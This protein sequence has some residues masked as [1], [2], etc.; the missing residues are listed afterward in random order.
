VRPSAQYTQIQRYV[1]ANERGE[2]LLDSRGTAA[3]YAL[4]AQQNLLHKIQAHEEFITKTYAHLLRGDKYLIHDAKMEP[5]L[6]EY[7]LH[8]RL[9]WPD[10]HSTG[11]GHRSW[12]A[13]HPVL[14]NAI[15]SSI[16]LTIADQYAFDIVTDDTTTHEA[17]ISSNQD[18]IFERLLGTSVLRAAEQQTTANELGQFG[19]RHDRPEFLG[20]QGL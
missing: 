2:R 18:Q 4:V 17:V 1:R 9:A 15:M 5:G 13:L 11:V 16:A 20:I 10:S 12:L 6:R 7:L 8:R 3:E 14:G 19:D